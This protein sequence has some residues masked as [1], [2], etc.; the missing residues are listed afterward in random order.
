MAGRRR[1]RREWMSL[2][3]EWRGSGLSQGAFGRKRG[4]APASLSYWVC[5]LRREQGSRATLLP[6]RL[7]E[8]APVAAADFRLDLARGRTL[9]VP[10]SFD[11]DAL[12]RLL[13][14]LERD[15]C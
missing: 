12:G 11:A 14:V 9:Y 1:T 3:A 15:A 2:V 7:V 10:P 13:A 5:R 4:I 8:A 6:V